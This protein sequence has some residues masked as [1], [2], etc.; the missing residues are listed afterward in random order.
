MINTYH[1]AIIVYCACFVVLVG[2][3]WASGNV[4]TPVCHAQI[5]GKQ[6]ITPAMIACEQRKLADYEEEFLPEIVNQQTLPHT[7]FVVTRN[8]L[9]EFGRQAKHITGNTP[10][11]L[12][13]WVLFQLIKDPY[14]ILAIQSLSLLCLF[15]LWVLLICRELGIRPF[16]GL[17]AAASSVTMPFLLYWLTFPMHIATVCWSAALLFGVMRIFHRR[18][19]FAWIIVAFGFYGMFLMGYPQTAVYSMWMIAGYVGVVSWPLIQRQQWWD[20]AGRV[21]TIGS[22]VLFGVVLMLP[23]YLDLFIR[24]RDSSRFWVKDDFFL[25]AIQS[26]D[27]LK[28]V[29]LYVVS[30]IVP[31]LYGNPSGTTYPLEFDGASLPLGVVGVLICAIVYRWRAVRWWL[32]C[33]GVL[34][35]LTVSP[36]LFTLVMYMFPG[37]RLSPW[38]PLWSAVIPTCIMLAYGWDALMTLP[39]SH[40]RRLLGWVIIGLIGVVVVGVVVGRA[41]GLTITIVDLLRI[42]V[43]LLACGMLTWRINPLTLGSACVVCLVV[44][45]TPLIGIQPRNVLVHDTPLTHTLQQAVP[46]GA[47]FAVV[48]PPIDYILAPN[49]NTL[50]GVAS[51]HSYNNFFTPYYQRIIGQLGGKITVYGKLNRAIAPHYESS[52]FWMSNIAVVLADHLIDHPNLQLIAQHDDVWVFHV[53][54]R[55]GQYWR[56]PVQYRVNIADIHIPDYHIPQTL[57]ITQYQNHGDMVE[58]T[59]PSTSTQS[60]IILSTLYESNWQAESFDGKEWKNAVPVSV[61]G[62]FLGIVVPAESRAV[63]IRYVTYVQYMWISHLMW[64][65]CF[66]GVGVW[67]WRDTRRTQK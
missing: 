56:I 16:A 63:Q 21:G 46:T 5:N 23:A 19:G 35:L 3:L 30:R 31:E 15:G 41:Q 10:A 17:L 26:L 61:N 25:Q 51:V 37:F 18:D 6:Y 47:R 36:T 67:Y 4:L 52:A 12:Y 2:L 60:L 40:V 54:Q 14:Q 50:I 29:L 66:S 65:L 8:E 1:R 42:G 27:T 24:Y 13:T 53:K 62:A 33:A 44:T 48:S 9:N 11:N 64:L 22:A 20:L 34:V 57:P 7:G 58:L 32:V 39:V 49:Y 59:Y 38:T 45:A 28:S 55:M 43:V